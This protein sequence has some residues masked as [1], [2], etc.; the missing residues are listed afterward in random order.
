MRRG[1]LLRTMANF[2]RAAGP[3]GGAGVPLRPPGPSSPARPSA[4]ASPALAVT[5]I[6]GGSGSASALQSVLPG[7]ALQSPADGTI[8]GWRVHGSVSNYNLLL[9]VMSPGTIAGRWTGGP[10]STAATFLDG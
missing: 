5:S 9:H 2:F 4:L 8:T 3:P 6:N 10:T 7:V 1:G